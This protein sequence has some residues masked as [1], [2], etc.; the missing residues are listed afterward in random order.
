MHN[1]NSLHVK[2]WHRQPLTHFAGFLQ[3][4]NYPWHEGTV[5]C[6]YHVHAC[7]PLRKGLACN[8]MSSILC[9]QSLQT[10]VHVA[11]QYCKTEVL[12]HLSKVPRVEIDSYDEVH[13]YSLKCNW[14][15]FLHEVCM[16]SYLDFTKYWID[17]CIMMDFTKW[18]L[19]TLEPLIDTS[20]NTNLLGISI[21]PF[22]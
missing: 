17:T 7:I 10:P 19:L 16:D 13:F 2:S 21:A 12:E 20:Y 8:R 4:N 18:S 3:C 15:P 22:V 14:T 11:A 6:M 9:V 5:L 1:N